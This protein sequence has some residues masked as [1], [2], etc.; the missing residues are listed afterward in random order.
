MVEFNINDHELISESFLTDSFKETPY[1]P[2]FYETERFLKEN[3]V[4]N[5]KSSTKDKKNKKKK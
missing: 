5:S 2:N 4:K 3:K 1:L